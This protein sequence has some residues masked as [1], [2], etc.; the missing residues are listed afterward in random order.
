MSRSH[1]Y[2]TSLKREQLFFSFPPFFIIITNNF[3]WHCYVRTHV[4]MSQCYLFYAF[5]YFSFLPFFLFPA[6]SNAG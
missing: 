6:L 2:V 3:K 5:S 1:K 4:C